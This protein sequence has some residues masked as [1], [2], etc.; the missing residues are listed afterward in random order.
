MGPEAFFLRAREQPQSSL[1]GL[2]SNGQDG[3]TGSVGER[4]PAQEEGPA[5][6][7]DA[8]SSNDDRGSKIVWWKPRQEDRKE[9]SDEEEVRNPFKAW[10]DEEFEEE[11]AAGDEDV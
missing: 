9:D 3:R 6:H 1:H 10:R 8:R 4:V 11:Q 7:P 5:H 2:S